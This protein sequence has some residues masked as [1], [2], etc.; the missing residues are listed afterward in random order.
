MDSHNNLF[1]SG[2]VI[3]EQK[4]Y[5]VSGFAIVSIVLTVLSLWF[6]QKV[7]VPDKWYIMVLIGSIL[8]FAYAVI[9]IM[10]LQNRLYPKSRDGKRYKDIVLFDEYLVGRFD[11]GGNAE[12]QDKIKFSEIEY[13]VQESDKEIR[14][15][16]KR[17]TSHRSVMEIEKMIG[18][19][20]EYLISDQLTKAQREELVN[21]LNSRIKEYSNG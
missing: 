1:K 16:F 7:G 20:Q 11:K 19:P 17:F 5:G 14:I 10:F 15:A 13:I 8:F 21:Y 2:Q 4:Q 3:L 18:G 9:L 6:F 12:N